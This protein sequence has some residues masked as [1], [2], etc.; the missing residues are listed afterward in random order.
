LISA[1]DFTI[2]GE[3]PQCKLTFASKKDSKGSGR[4]TVGVR[5]G[6]DILSQSF[7][8]EIKTLSAA[9]KASSSRSN[10]PAWIDFTPSELESSSGSK[11]ISWEWDFG[12]ST[13]GRAMNFAKQFTR[14]GTYTVKLKIKDDSGQEDVASTQVTID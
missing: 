9:F 7:S 6:N 2:G 14:S 11:I 12:D 13:S 4:V 1:K 8:I 3:I 5:V 10:S